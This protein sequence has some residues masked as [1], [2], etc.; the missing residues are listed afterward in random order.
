MQRFKIPIYKY[1][2]I[3]RKKR[4]EIGTP[5][6]LCMLGKE[7]TIPEWVLDM[8]DQWN[9]GSLN[10]A[11][12]VPLLKFHP[13]LMP[14]VLRQQ[15]ESWIRT[16]QPNYNSRCNEVKWRTNV[17]LNNQPSSQPGCVHGQ[18]GRGVQTGAPDQCMVIAHHRKAD[19]MEGRNRTQGKILRSGKII[20]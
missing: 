9:N 3:L 10:D 16:L 13:T 7:I 20:W 2:N 5:D 14:Q 8:K 4:K 11:I 15:E 12:I 19:Q 1:T 17:I 6:L 18:A